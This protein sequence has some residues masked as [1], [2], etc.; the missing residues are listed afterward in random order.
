MKKYYIFLTH[1][2]C[3]IGGMQ[4][5]V[6]RKIEYLK[7]QGWYP[8]VFFYRGGNIEIDNLKEYSQNH[9]TDLRF[10]VGNVSSK[11]RKKVLLQIEES[12]HDK[13]EVIVESCCLALGTWGEYIASHNHGKHILYIIDEIIS[14]PTSR[15]YNFLEFKANQNL[16]YCI[17]QKV[18]AGVFKDNIN[19]EKFVL[20]AIG[21]TSKNISDVYN[22]VVSSIPD[23]VR[24]ILSLGR[25][26][27]PYIGHLFDSIVMFANSFPEY[28]FNFVIVGDT[29]IKGAKEE[30]LSKF[31]NIRNVNVFDLGFLWPIPKHLFDK[32]DVAVGAA[33]SINLCSRQGVPSISIDV[34]DY[35]AIGLY[36]QNTFNSIF[37]NEN[38]PSETIVGWLDKILIQNIIG[39]R[40]PERESTL[41][42][43]SHQRI[44]DM[45]V[46]NRYFP[47][48]KSVHFVSHPFFRSAIIRFDETNWG[49]KIIQKFWRTKWF[50]NVVNK[51]NRNGY[52]KQ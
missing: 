47:T 50:N 29:P 19:L 23:D 12:L 24:T 28:R 13:Q 43:S 2:I 35:E 9:I 25:L 14:K 15:M 18:L 51:I 8:L 49:H 34:N 42:Y 36:G 32:V 45:D 44:I 27:K 52:S 26:D 5:Y 39:K 40:E 30:L 21:T 17:K 1:C 38:D 46:E 20:K 48:E 16:L 37:R 7:N 33:G 31:E 22:P 3:S 11:Y 10:C 6:S 41:D 4:L